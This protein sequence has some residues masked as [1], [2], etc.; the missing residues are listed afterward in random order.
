[1]FYLIAFAIGFVVGAL[2]FRNNASRASKL[3]ADTQ[4]TLEADKMVARNILADLNKK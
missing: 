2:T 3:L 4:A 1:M